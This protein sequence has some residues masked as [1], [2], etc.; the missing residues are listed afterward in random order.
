MENTSNK[1]TPKPIALVAEHYLGNLSEQP[2]LANEKEFSDASTALLTVTIDRK[3]RCKGRIFTTTDSGQPIGI[4]K[5]RNWLLRDG[6]VLETQDH[7]R[8]V[9]RIHLQKVIALQIDH[10]AHN[11]GVHLVH[12]G[13]VL[14]NHHWPITVKGN[15]LYIETVANE[16]LIESTIRE[17]VQT[18][19]IQ[20]VTI[21]REEKSADQAIEF[22][23]RFSA[24]SMPTHA[25]SHAH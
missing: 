24:N 22:S 12:L 13:H 9:V 5:G 17:V 8:I 15:A 21:T 10:H 18:L 23:A 2:T 19:G 11:A 6:D 3:D 14:G 7:Q 1:T 16:T 25:H 4:V 20:G